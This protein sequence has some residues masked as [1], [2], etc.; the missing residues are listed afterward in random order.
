MIVTVHNLAE[1][2]KQDVFDT[3]ARHLLTQREPSA[4]EDGTSCLY[5]G[6]DGKRCAAGCLLTEPLGKLNDEPWGR[7]VDAGVVPGAHRELI[8][9]LQSIHDDATCRDRLSL[10][11]M[12]KWPLR[13]RSLAGEL[14]L[15]DS[16]V[17]EMEG[18]A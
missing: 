17:A 14:G 13:L 15:S 1:A 16:V 11:P 8:E 3:I 4:S 12:V 18:A 6:P 10:P 2:T 7:L 5:F 9:D